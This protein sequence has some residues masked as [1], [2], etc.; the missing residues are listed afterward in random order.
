MENK[1]LTNQNTQTQE[2]PKLTK[3]IKERISAFY[4]WT[5]THEFVLDDMLA[6]ICGV[7]VQAGVKGLSHEIKVAGKTFS[8]LV[9]EKYENKEETTKVEGK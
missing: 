6:I 7:L 1:P 4:E 2:P 8:I 3:T 9:E 5:A